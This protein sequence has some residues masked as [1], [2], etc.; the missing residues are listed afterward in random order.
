VTRK[1][2]RLVGQI[3]KQ[4][5]KR[6]RLV[7]QLAKQNEKREELVQQLARQLRVESLYGIKAHEIRK[8]VLKP[9][10]RCSG[11]IQY[12]SVVTMKDGSQ[13]A[14]KGVNIKYELD[15]REV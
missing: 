14:I 2:E 1:R 12:G 15:E 13:H 8:I 10:G 5:E 7:R 3:A 11:Q 6:E 9:E 4:N